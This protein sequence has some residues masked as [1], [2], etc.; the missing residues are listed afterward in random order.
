MY[1]THC[2]FNDIDYFKREPYHINWNLQHIQKGD[3]LELLDSTVS[4]RVRPARVEKVIGTRILVRVNQK[5]LSQSAVESGDEDDNQVR[6]DVFFE[7]NSKF[8][9]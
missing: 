9:L 8:F 1:C 7:L 3:Q 4:M 5:L 2:F 6:E